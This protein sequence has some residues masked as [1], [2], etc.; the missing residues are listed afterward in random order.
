MADWFQPIG[1]IIATL[2]AVSLSGIIS[3]SF[4]LINEA[5]RLKKSKIEYPTEVK[6]QLYIPYQLVIILVRW[7]R[8][9]L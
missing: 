1:I 8:F 2:A 5:M 3:G 9:A 6:G 4:T 7:Y